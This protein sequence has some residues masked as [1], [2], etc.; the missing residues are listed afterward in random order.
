MFEWFNRVGYSSNIEALR[1]EFPDV[2]WL[3]FKNWVSKQDW[4]TLS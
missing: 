3:S 1:R 4:S 2:P